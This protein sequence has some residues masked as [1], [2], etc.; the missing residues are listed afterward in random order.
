MH[1]VDTGQAIPAH[2]VDHSRLFSLAGRSYVV[3][4]AGGGIGE[5]VSRTVVGMGG[6][7]LCVD[8]NEEPVAAVAGSLHP[9]TW[10]GNEAAAMRRHWLPARCSGGSANHSK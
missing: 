6:R 10:P 3:L 7:V 5:H 2:Q 9:D 4:G 1:I 8:I